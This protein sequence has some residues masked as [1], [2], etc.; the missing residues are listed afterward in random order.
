MTDIETATAI[1][2]HNLSATLSVVGAE[3]LHGGMVNRVEKWTT[4][5]EPAAIVAKL[6]EQPDKQDFY[7]EYKSLAWYRQ[8][9]SFPVPEP[10]ACISGAE[11]SGTCLLMECAKGENLSRARITGRG[12]EH[13]QNELAR[14]LIDLH[15]HRRDSYGSCL[16][17]AGP[18]RWLDIFAPQ[19]ESNFNDSK[20]QLSRSC[21]ETV[22]RLL[23]NLDKWLPEYNQPTLIHGDIW[24][25]N[26][27]IDDTDVDRPVITAF[28]DVNAR[29]AEV[30]YELA[31]LRVFST[32]DEVFFAEY[33]KAHPLR[34]GFDQRCLVYWLNT[35]MLHVAAFGSAYVSSCEG[36]ARRI[37]LLF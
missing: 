30:E 15:T 27:M 18:K 37:S 17:A 25:T 23:S 35:M 10:Y 4:D 21:C 33:S 9:S 11:F 32:A 28:L 16:E 3:S 22:E 26:I 2:R 19:I 36:I 7:T 31:Y 24:A 5:G 34:P 13:F 8:N 1:V 12:M 20:G 29:Y 14:I 6:S